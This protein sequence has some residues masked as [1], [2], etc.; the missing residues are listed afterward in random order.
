[1]GVAALGIS[2]SQLVVAYC[3]TFREKLALREM[4]AW[5]K[6]AVITLGR[7]GF[8]A[9]AALIALVGL[10]LVQAAVHAEPDNAGGMAKALATLVEQPFGPGL[11]GATAAGLIA[12]GLFTW[13]LMRYRDLG[14]AR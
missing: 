12:H 3:A 6:I 14:G 2:I 13:A 8:C 7:M 10:F 11:L 4:H 5:E 9:R 1:M